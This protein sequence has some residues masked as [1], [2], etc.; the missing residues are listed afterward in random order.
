MKGKAKKVLSGMLSV[1]TILTSFVQPMTTFA[2]EPEPAAYE[3]E[4]PALDK[5]RAELSEDEIVT[6]QDYEMEAGDSFDV[7]SDFSDMEIEDEK[8][9]VKFHEAKDENGQNY[10]SNRAGIYKAVYFVEPVSGNPSYHVV[11]KIIVKEPSVG[12]QEGKSSASNPAEQ[13]EESGSEEGESEAHSEMAVGT[14][15]ATETELET[16]QAEAVQEESNLAENAQT[17]PLETAGETELLSEKE[18]DEALEAAQEQDTVDEETGLTLGNVMLQAVE[19]GVDL[20]ELEE[21]ESVEFTAAAPRLYAARASQRVT[22]TAGSW[23]YYADYG[24]GS[25]LTCPYTVTFGNV[26]AVAYC[27]QPSKP[28]P[29]DGTYTIERLSDGKTLAKVCYYGTKA[30]G[31]DGFFEEKH[32]DFSTGKR[33]IITHLAAAYANGSSDAFEGTNST[34][35]ALAMELYNYCVS[36]PDIPD[37]AM[38]FSKANVTAYVDGNSQRTEEITFKADTQQTITMKLPEGVKFHNVTTGKI[39]KAGAE[40]EVCGGTKFYLSAPLTQTKDVSGAWSATMKG[41]I[42]K[43]YSAYKITT[44]SNTQDLALVFGEGVTDEKCGFFCKMAGTGKGKGSKSGFQKDGCEAVR[45]GIR[46]LQ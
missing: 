5:V 33:F 13:T 16:V 3:A 43:D 26:T 9:K 36:Q 1:I 45:C 44:G 27:V 7:E 46:Y 32:P 20:L 30:S 12:S 10:D 38:S 31:E 37:V 28:G 14:E 4:Y 39:S 34:G 15:A 6:V 21:G 25:Y 18:L 41:S 35:Q 8:V 22:V 42:T 40:V 29:D 11:R 17:E 24:L 19:Q 2:A 23:Y